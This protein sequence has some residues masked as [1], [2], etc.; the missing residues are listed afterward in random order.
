MSDYTVIVNGLFSLKERSPKTSKEIILGET[1]SLANEFNNTPISSSILFTQS[2]LDNLQ[3]RQRQ[4][5]RGE[6][7]AMEYLDLISQQE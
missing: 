7:S 1:N 5:Q 6:I 4:L 3:R 2:S